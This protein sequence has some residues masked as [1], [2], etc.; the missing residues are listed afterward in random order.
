MASS[1]GLPSSPAVGDTHLVGDSTYIWTGVVWN[2]VTNPVTQE[3]VQDVL[4]PLL[5]H[6]NHTNIT[7]TYDDLNNKILLSG[8]AGGG[9]STD[10]ALI[11]GLS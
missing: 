3:Q 10:I 11:I 6:S 9:G 7:A 5:V 8:S 4:A 1:F 2:Q